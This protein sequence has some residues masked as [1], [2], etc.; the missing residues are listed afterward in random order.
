MT[1]LNGCDVCGGAHTND[2]HLA[3]ERH[4]R[5]IVR[6][7]EQSCRKQIVYLPNPQTGSNV[8]VDADTVEPADT[9]YESG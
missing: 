6:C 5:R 8:P 9:E 1:N 4:E 3:E 2:E 7:R